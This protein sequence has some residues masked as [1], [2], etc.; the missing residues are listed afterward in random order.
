MTKVPCGGLILIQKHT[1]GEITHTLVT[2]NTGIRLKTRQNSTSLIGLNGDCPKLTDRPQRS[3][4]KSWLEISRRTFRRWHVPFHLKN[5]QPRLKRH[6]EQNNVEDVGDWSD[7]HWLLARVK[8]SLDD[9]RT[10]LPYHY[11]VQVIDENDQVSRFLTSS[12]PLIEMENQPTKLLPFSNRHCLFMSF[13]PQLIG[14]SPSAITCNGEIV[15]G[16]NHLT[17]KNSWQYVY[18]NTPD[19]DA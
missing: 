10:Y 14:C 11:S 2:K 18:S 15:A 16:I 6:L 12:N 17:I 5:N 4:I 13:D 8:A 3:L 7:D 1:R 19:F 9:W